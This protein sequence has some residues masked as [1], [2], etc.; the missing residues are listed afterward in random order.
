MPLLQRMSNLMSAHVND[1]LDWCEDP[2]KMLR[3]IVRDLE[4]K[5]QA[6]QASAVEAIAHEKLL[7][8][9]LK[10]VQTEADRWQHLAQ[11]Q[12]DQRNEHEARLALQERFRCQ[13][14]TEMLTGNLEQ[15]KRTATQ[16]RRHVQTLQ[17]QLTETRQQLISF[18]TRVRLAELSTHGTP[19]HPSCKVDSQIAIN[20]W[21]EQLHLAEARLEAWKEFA[22]DLDGSLDHLNL[23]ARVER[24]LAAMRQGGE[25]GTE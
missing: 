25:H 19:L 18:T 10:N 23:D 21:L 1:W 6:T 3:Q 2:E 4:Q 8:R 13:D 14:L 12:L 22:E 17:R 9:Q 16:L 7:T 5:V 24:E 15:I 11:T 20:R